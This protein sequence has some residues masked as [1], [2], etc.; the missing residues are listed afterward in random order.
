MKGQ[1]LIELECK[2][3]V[4]SHEPVRTWLREAGAKY[5]GRVLET[6]RLFDRADRSLMSGGCGLRVRSVEILDGAGPQSTLTLKGP[7]QAGVY[8]RRE[9]IEVAVGDGEATVRL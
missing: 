1:A 6:N 5:V 7:L 2:V 3:A 4:D 8:K 9:E